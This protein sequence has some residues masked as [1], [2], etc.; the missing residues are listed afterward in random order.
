MEK[1]RYC[2]RRPHYFCFQKQ[3]ER[4]VD[5]FKYKNV[6]KGCADQ[7]QLSL[8]IRHTLLFFISAYICL[9]MSLAK[10]KQTCIILYL[11]ESVSHG[12]LHL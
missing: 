2:V 6:M 11:S 12:V 5:P 4:D 8:C 1:D 9:A 10:T 3:K 7:G